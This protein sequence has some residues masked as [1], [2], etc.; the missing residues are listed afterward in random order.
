MDRNLLLPILVVP[1]V[2]LISLTVF[3]GFSEGTQ[4]FYEGAVTN[5]FLGNVTSSPITLYSDY[6]AKMGSMDVWVRNATGNYNLAIGS[7]A[8]VTIDYRSG[9][10]VAKI[11]ITANETGNAIKAYA[12]YTG[13]IQGSH[14]SSF[15][16]TYEKSLN[17]YNLGALLPYIL[18]AMVLIGVIIKFVL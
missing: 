3:Q 8:N 13:Y 7:A 9:L 12:N 15:V 10:R 4:S 17:T 16:T 6:P 1:L 11:T 5:E 2:L 14:Y 18:A